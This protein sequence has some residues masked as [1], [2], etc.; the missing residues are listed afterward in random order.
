M[1]VNQWIELDENTLAADMVHHGEIQE[2]AE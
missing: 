1:V 2:E